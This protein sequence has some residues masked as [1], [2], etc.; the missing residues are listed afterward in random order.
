MENML[1]EILDRLDS[2]DSRMEKLEKN[3]DF[4]KNEATS[5]NVSIKGMEKLVEDAADKIFNIYDDVK[6]IRNN[7]K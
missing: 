2:L 6:L 3:M 5:N 1:K 7:T 4:I